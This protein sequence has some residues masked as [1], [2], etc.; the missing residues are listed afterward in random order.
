MGRFGPWAILVIFLGWQVTLCDPMWQ[1]TLCSSETGSDEALYT[2]LTLSKT[3]DVLCVQA[4]YWGMSDDLQGCKPC[5]CD[6]GGAVDDRCDQRTGQCTCRPNVI[7]RRCDDVAPGYF[8]PALDWERYE[9]EKARGIGVSANLPLVI[10]VVA[11]PWRL[12]LSTVGNNCAK[13]NFF[14]GGVRRFY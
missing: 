1:V 10:V 14:W 2:A 12:S 11:Y 8:V 13:D 9:A 4:G 7:G 5:D 3:A 6:V